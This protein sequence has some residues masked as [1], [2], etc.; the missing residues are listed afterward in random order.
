M[1][2]HAGFWAYVRDQ[3]DKSHSSWNNY[4]LKRNAALATIQKAKAEGSAVDVWDDTAWQYNRVGKDARNGWSK[5]TPDERAAFM[6]ANPDPAYHGDPSGISDTRKVGVKLESQPS[7]KPRKVGLKSEPSKT[8]VP[9]ANATPAP[10]LRP[11]EYRDLDK[12]RRRYHQALFALA[13]N[14]L[15]DDEV[16][17]ECRAMDIPVVAAARFVEIA[18]VRALEVLPLRYH[19]AV[20]NALA[21]SI[22]TMRATVSARRIG[23]AEE[24]KQEVSDSAAFVKRAG[25]VYL[26]AAR[27]AMVVAK[28]QGDPD[29]DPQYRL[30]EYPKGHPCYEWFCEDDSETFGPSQLAYSPQAVASNDETFKTLKTKAIK[31]VEAFEAAKEVTNKNN[32]EIVAAITEG[33]QPKLSREAMARFDDDVARPA[34]NKMV[35]DTSIV[36]NRRYPGSKDIPSAAYFHES[37]VYRQGL[38]FESNKTKP[39]ATKKTKKRGAVVFTETKKAY[40]R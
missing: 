23:S 22:K 29:P 7:N 16:V 25:E 6:E 11:Q 33:R 27:N 30:V 13:V 39:D 15:Q 31:S 19:D 24:R 26:K 9:T 20:E 21:G 37:V 28:A 38:P 34:Y 40:G 10:V 4:L 5:L 18:T 12:A 14:E 1:Y 17:R 2:A 36:A 32:K 35:V 3:A 8:T